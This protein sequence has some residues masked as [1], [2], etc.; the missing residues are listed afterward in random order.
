MGVDD[1]PRP[2]T[3]R[4]ALE[5]YLSPDQV[6]D[7]EAHGRVRVNAVPVDDIDQEIPPDAVVGLWST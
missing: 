6:Q 7:H 1:Q 4:Q 2:R 3:A 5:V